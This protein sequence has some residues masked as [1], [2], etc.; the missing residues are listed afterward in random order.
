[1]PFRISGKN[2]DIG[3]ALRTRIN[4]RIGESVR[5][6][7][8]GGFSGHVTVDKEGYGFRTECAIHLD[9][10][11]ILHADGMAS[12]A[13]A[14]ADQAALRLEKRLRRYKDRLKKPPSRGD[15]R[16]TGPSTFDAASYVIAAPDH[17]ADEPTPFNAAVIAESTT[18]LETLSVSEAVSE[19][20]LTGA[21][22]VVFRHAASG[23]VNIVYRRGDGNIGWID[24][25]APKV[26]Q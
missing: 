16:I 8:D 21:P 1:M 3:D 10:G 11:I 5:K 20:D 22:V 7:F 24:P 26:G 25:P 2:M 15:G 18:V 13:Y 4:D 19:L 17:D 14:S 6:F 9:S 23:R 12:D